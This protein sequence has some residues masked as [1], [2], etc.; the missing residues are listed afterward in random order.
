MD[1]TVPRVLPHH[2]SKNV[3]ELSAERQKESTSNNSRI[4]PFQRRTSNSTQS[5]FF[6]LHQTFYKK[7]VQEKYFPQ[8]KLSSTEQQS[9]YTVS[10]L[11]QQK[12]VQLPPLMSHKSSLTPMRDQNF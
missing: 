6:D 4:S 1:P 7:I 10:Q 8:A 9:I 2:D 3:I 12:T 11:S 5:T